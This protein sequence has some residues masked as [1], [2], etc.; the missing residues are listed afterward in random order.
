MILGNRN[1]RVIERVIAM[2]GE[3][4]K[5]L[6]SGRFAELD[7]AATERDAQLSR[8]GPLGADSVSALGPRVAALRAAARRNADLIKAALE[9][10][11][12]GQKRLTAMREARTNLNTYDASGAPHAQVMTGARPGRRA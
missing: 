5:L 7:A 6:L 3:E 8:L 12:A 9:G 2:L 1:A 11:A 10:A 4:R